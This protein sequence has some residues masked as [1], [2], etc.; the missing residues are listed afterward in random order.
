M[1]NYNFPAKDEEGGSNNLY[2]TTAAFIH[3]YDSTIDLDFEY[4]IPKLLP[5]ERQPIS[6][7]DFDALPV[8]SVGYCHSLPSVPSLPDHE[9]L[10]I[11]TNVPPLSRISL[12]TILERIQLKC[13]IKKWLVVSRE[14][15]EKSSATP[16]PR[17]SFGPALGRPGLPQATVRRV[18]K[19]EAVI[20]KQY[21]RMN[22]VPAFSSLTR[23]LSPVV[24]RGQWEI[25]MRSM[26]I[27]FF[28]SWIILGSLLAIPPGR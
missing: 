5:Q 17:S 18:E 21:K 8:R 25:A 26:A 15:A 22:A 6:A 3:P 7:F 28:M 4:E 1:F 11:K 9:I 10:E 20:Q 23:I 12:T 24:V 16:S 27:A 13:N 14:V 19:G 2:A